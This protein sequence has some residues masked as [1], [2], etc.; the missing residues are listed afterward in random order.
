MAHAQLLAGRIPEAE[1]VPLDAG[2]TPMVEA[3][4]GYGEALR[5][6]AALSEVDLT[7]STK[8]E[9]QWCRQS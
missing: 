4:E 1:L 8:G 9:S 2:H 3:P 6:L 7:R 5:R